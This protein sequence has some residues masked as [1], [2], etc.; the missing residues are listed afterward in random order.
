MKGS[1]IKCY[2]GASIG[3]E[4]QN[5]EEKTCDEGV[6]QCTKTLASALGGNYY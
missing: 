3:N 5:L 2:A 6:T 4:A 1:K